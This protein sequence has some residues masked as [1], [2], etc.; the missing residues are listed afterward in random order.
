MNTVKVCSK[1]RILE[2]DG[3]DKTMT[4]VGETAPTV[5]VLS[6]WNRNEWAVIEV[7]GHKYTVSIRDLTT[8]LKNAGNT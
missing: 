5:T 6:H 8:A 3:K 4:P 7:G 1:V 2:L